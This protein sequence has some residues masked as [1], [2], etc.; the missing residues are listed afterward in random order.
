MENNDQKKSG[1]G[2]WI[3]VAVCIAF[4]IAIVFYLNKTTDNKS[5]ISPS[6]QQNASLNG[7]EGT[8]DGPGASK[9]IGDIGGDP[10]NPDGIGGKDSDSGKMTETDDTM[11]GGANQ[12]GQ[13]STL[14]NKNVDLPAGQKPSLKGYEGTGDGP[15][16]SKKIGDIGGDPANPDGIGGKDSDSGTM[17]ETDDIMLGGARQLNPDETADNIKDVSQR[18]SGFKHIAH[19]DFNSDV[20]NQAEVNNIKEEIKKHCTKGCKI[21]IEGHTCWVGTDDYNNDL[22]LRRANFISRVIKEILPQD[23]NPEI[24]VDGFGESKLI[25]KNNKEANRRVEITI[26]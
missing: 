10:A 13:D 18:K 2:K 11:L 20:L 5:E 4:V 1:N 21:T 9:K 16:A 15:G 22:S 25:D 12:T 23:A 17:T 8:G 6:A 24:Q 26:F 14:D 3:V 7:Y 19:F